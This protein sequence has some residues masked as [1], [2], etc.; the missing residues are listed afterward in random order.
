MLKSYENDIAGNI[1]AHALQTEIIN[2]KLDSDWRG[3]YEIYL[4]KWT[5]KILELENL[6]TASIPGKDKRIWLESTLSS[7]E[8]MARNFADV[9]TQ[10][11]A[12]A[13]L[14]G[15]G[16][17]ARL[18]FDD[19]FALIMQRTI[20]LDNY[21]KRT[22]VPTMQRN[23]SAS[24]IKHN[25]NNSSRQFTEWTGPE[26]IMELGMSFSNDDWKNKIT[27]AQK[28]DLIKLH[29]DARNTNTNF[30]K[31]GYNTTNNT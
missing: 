18:E 15:K 14:N 10:E 1:Q 17:C 6:E 30:T 7:N 8:D 9:V 13:I 5:N 25:N 3:C 24:Q 22:D 31:L 20:M 21:R 27:K 16:E 26:M 12:N 23:N 29:K 11:G 2:M 4:H 19:L 28:M